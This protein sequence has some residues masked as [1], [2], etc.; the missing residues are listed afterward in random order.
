MRD[1][2]LL[3]S[4]L[5]ADWANVFLQPFSGAVTIWPKTRAWDWVRILSD[6]DRTELMRMIRVGE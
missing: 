6:P 2:D 5:G 4:I 1:L 3:P